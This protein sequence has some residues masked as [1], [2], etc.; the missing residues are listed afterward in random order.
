MWQRIMFSTSVSLLKCI[1]MWHSEITFLTL[2]CDWLNIFQCF[3]CYELL[4]LFAVA[5]MA[6]AGTYA[7]ND[8]IVAFARLHKLTVVIHQLDSPVWQVGDQPHTLRSLIM[9]YIHS[10][11]WEPL[12]IL[13]MALKS[14]LMFP[15]GWQGMKLT[16]KSTGQTGR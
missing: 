15:W 2:S 12:L 8:C 11:K 14:L 10:C 16:K 3:H 13:F 7:G 1:G 6:K 4:R 9:K 5:M